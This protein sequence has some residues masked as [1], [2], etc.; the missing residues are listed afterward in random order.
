MSLSPGV[1]LVAG[2]LLGGT[3]MAHGVVFTA[4]HEFTCWGLTS[5]IK[6]LLPL[7]VIWKTGVQGDG[8]E[9]QALAK[10]EG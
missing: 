2:L 3:W 5:F 9:V 6:S 8:S 1:G 7:G 10:Q 4:F